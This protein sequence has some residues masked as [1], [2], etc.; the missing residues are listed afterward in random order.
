MPPSPLYKYLALNVEVQWE[1]LDALLRLGQIYL[2][3]PW[4]FNDLF[5]VRPEILVPEAQ[6]P[7]YLRD[8]DAA[9]RRLGHP[10]ARRRRQIAVVTRDPNRVAR[11]REVALNRIREV[12]VFC[13]TPN[14]TNE[15]MWAHYADSNRG[16]CVGFHATRGPLAVASPVEYSDVAPMYDRY[17][18]EGFRNIFVTK[19]ERWRYEEEYRLVSLDVGGIEAR[20]EAMRGAEHDGDL[21]RFLGREPG[22]G[23]LPI[24]RDLIASIT[25]GY[26]CPAQDRQRAAA[27]VRREGLQIE[28]FEVFVE[29]ASRS[30]SVRPCRVP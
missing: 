5:D 21:M 23:I 9:G 7:R 29:D 26:L 2:A 8:L 28:L 6:D 22:P 4:Q 27:L 25:F 12:G 10:H 14:R 30:L 20:I 18:V 13:V 1:R 24:S 11:Y 19:R 17:V 15:L 16:I 3:S